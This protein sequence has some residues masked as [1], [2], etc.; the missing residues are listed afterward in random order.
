MINLIRQK[1]EH[2]ATSVRTPLKKIKD[3]GAKNTPARVKT[4]RLME[5]IK[6]LFLAS[7]LSLSIISAGDILAQRVGT[8]WTIPSQAQAQVKE[9]EDQ[10]TLIISIAGIGSY[11]KG[12]SGDQLFNQVQNM[13]GTKG[14]QYD[15]STVNRY[16]I[17]R[18]GGPDM[19]PEA[20]KAEA[21]QFAKDATQSRHRIIKFQT[22]IPGIDDL[23]K[24][25]VK[26]VSLSNINSLA[27]H[28]T[29]TVLNNPDNSFKTRWEAETR[30]GAVSVEA[31][32]RKFKEENPNARVILVGHSAGTDLIDLIPTVDN[33]TGKRL[34]DLRVMSSPRMKTLKYN[35]E[36]D[37]ARTLFITHKSDFP[38]SP[39]GKLNVPTAGGNLESQGL[40]IEM[41][42]G[43]KNNYN[44]YE[45]HH[46]TF[47]Y[48]KD[49]K[50]LIK[51]PGGHVNFDGKPEDIIRKV[52]DINS[53]P[54]IDGISAPDQLKKTLDIE[55]SRASRVGGVTFD[56]PAEVPLDPSD[57]KE[58]I[59]EYPFDAILPEAAG[60]R[61]Y[62]FSFLMKSGEK[63]SLPSINP[64][65]AAE[66]FLCIN[67]GFVPEIGLTTVRDTENKL[68]KQ[69]DY[70]NCKEYLPF[71][72]LGDILFE[73]DNL[74]GEIAFEKTDAVKSPMFIKNFHNYNLLSYDNKLNDGKQ[75]S[76]IWLNPSS[77]RTELFVD[78][79]KCTTTRMQYHFTSYDINR[80]SEFY[81]K[82]YDGYSDPAGEFLSDQLTNNFEDLLFPE[83]AIVPETACFTGA[84]LW[85]YNNHIPVSQSTLD[86]SLRILNIDRTR[87]ING[88]KHALRAVQDD[89]TDNVIFL[90]NKPVA[91]S[92]NP[93][94]NDISRPA[95]IFDQWGLSRLL[96]EDGTQSVVEHNDNMKGR[97][98][99]LI[100]RQNDKDGK[101]DI[102]TI[103]YDSD[104]RLIAMV[105]SKYNGIAI[106]WTKGMPIL[107]RHVSVDL[108]EGNV[109]F[110][111]YTQYEMVDDVSNVFDN[112]LATW[113]EKQ[114]K[115]EP[116]DGWLTL[117][118]WYDN[119]P[120][121]ELLIIIVLIVL[122][123]QLW[124][125]WPT[126][127]D[128]GGRIVQLL[129]HLKTGGHQADAGGK[130]TPP[131]PDHV[132]RLLMKD[133]KTPSARE[134]LAKIGD[135]AVGQLV[136][137]V[138]SRA[139]NLRNVDHAFDILEKIASP[140]SVE[141][142]VEMLTKT[143]YKYRQQDILRILAAV[144]SPAAERLTAL[145]HA[146]SGKYVSPKIESLKV[147]I[148]DVLKKI[149][150]PH[151]VQAL[152]SLLKKEN[153]VDKVLETIGMLED[154][155]LAFLR[156]NVEALLSLGWRPKDVDEE[157]VGYIVNPKA[158]QKVSNEAVGSLIN[159]LKSQKYAVQVGAAMVLERLAEPKAAESLIAVMDNGRLGETARRALIRIGLD[160]VIPLTKALSSSKPEIKAQVL[161][162]LKSIDRNSVSDLNK[163]L[164]NSDIIDLTSAIKSKNAS[165]RLAAVK[166][167]SQK[168]KNAQVIEFL[169]ECMKDLEYEVKK[170]VLEILE[171]IDTDGVSGLARALED[172]DLKVCWKAIEVLG[173]KEKNNQVIVLLE[174]ALK[175]PDIYLRLEAVRILV[176]HKEI[177]EQV[178]TVLKETLRN[179]PM[180]EKLAAANVILQSQ[181]SGLTASMA[182]SVIA[183]M[184]DIV[185][186]GS[187]GYRSE[188]LEVIRQIK[189]FQGN[190]LLAKLTECVKEDGGEADIEKLLNNSIYEDKIRIL[191]ILENIEK[192]GVKGLRVSIKDT[193]QRVRL[194]VVELLGLKK[195]NDQ[196]I[197]LLEEALLDTDFSV[198]MESARALIS[199][200]EKN[201][202]LIAFL[203]IAIKAPEYKLRAQAM[204]E[205]I[206]IGPVASGI[207]NF[208]ADIKDGG[209]DAHLA[210]PEADKTE[211][212]AVRTLFEK[213][214]DTNAIGSD[215]AVEEL[216][217][218][219]DPLL[220]KTVTASMRGES[221]AVREA[222]LNK[223]IKYRKYFSK[224]ELN[225]IS[226]HDFNILAESRHARRY[227]LMTAVLAVDDSR[228]TE[229]LIK[230]L[231]NV[232]SNEA[233]I[234]ALCSSNNPQ[235]IE[236]LLSTVK[237][238]AVEQDIR[239]QIQG[240][241]IRF[242]NPRVFMTLKDL[243]Y[244]RNEFT[245]VRCAA[246]EELRKFEDP[247][248][249]VILKNLFEDKNE[250]PEVHSAVEKALG[251]IGDQ[252]GAKLLKRAR[253]G[254][255]L[256]ESLARAGTGLA[257]GLGTLLLGGVGLV[258]GLVWLAVIIGV[259][260]LVLWLF[261]Y[262]FF[263]GLP[264][265]IVYIVLL[266][267]IGVFNNST[268]ND[269]HDQKAG[270]L[271]LPK[272]LSLV[273]LWKLESV[274]DE[275]IALNIAELELVDSLRPADYVK[276]FNEH[277]RFYS[278]GNLSRLFGAAAMWVS[279]SFVYLCGRLHGLSAGLAMETARK[280]QVS[281]HAKW[282]MDEIGR[283]VS[284][285]QLSK[286][287]G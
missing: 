107:C 167:L 261:S 37:N 211:S 22:E 34:V 210:A 43:L 102:T 178:E 42:G 276:F 77:I 93:D 2:A 58:L 86:S 99:K 208:K 170:Q 142:L 231:K 21:K 199:H 228:S 212:Q 54:I 246:I 157:I 221:A 80:R 140:G 190:V 230:A 156:L 79:L 260:I 150:G 158:I 104:G 5:K 61:N 152:E 235:S 32:I 182:E 286:V 141:P 130:E 20:Q 24:A 83:L 106:I 3:K 112:L 144:G 46:K 247:G 245:K 249:F 220:E 18:R 271:I 262:S 177:N 10:P 97:I 183:G 136:K 94:L 179:P 119:L 172:S 88:N 201:D 232:D 239:C 257:K 159:E 266:S 87:I 207:A 28:L 284:G 138:Q 252:R 122:G 81:A 213:V 117:A 52:Q 116:T 173:R 197:A 133:I 202:S 277:F 103:L 279:T 274:P 161:E 269:H 89:N 148:I 268:Y 222:V 108:Q 78:R 64:A 85:A 223:F 165:M 186:H 258:I 75:S 196:V 17:T 154:N 71:T 74:S 96:W 168:N 125:F 4:S 275:T 188:G 155:N 48:D 114:T 236:L 44:P 13:F 164:K 1:T 121:K 181:D 134:A 225:N 111:R 200:G 180:N 124:I 109:Y 256:R 240:A 127:G 285:E 41:H 191:E 273:S 163:D 70:K 282:D 76:I 265:A 259:G 55:K 255:S 100:G 62:G 7:L 23:V 176:R 6:M 278:G 226:A 36:G 30:R 189:E 132:I 203:K 281:F 101:K 251:K 174:E 47:E 69:A 229:L 59:F 195:K 73:A 16:D 113:F 263:L 25:N 115:N 242:K 120:I 56:K 19:T 237:D 162:I 139:F 40:V 185:E 129:K 49:V 153:P 149:G 98:E 35:S 241:L 128:G 84:L 9:S 72:T 193:N 14:K 11:E 244:D 146:N 15:V 12:R 184:K 151:T 192:D 82:R 194:K 254:A 90:T 215:Q 216:F 8:S 287:I 66:A 131:E 233:A 91:E 160:A 39:F 145:L 27:R 187:S 234:E 137:A 53:R 95:P 243:S 26:D 29:D 38:A 267:K 143:A 238:K 205:A 65:T 272:N 209:A 280:V 57:I 105:D 224:H 227:L 45:A 171:K 50:M 264:A 63:I 219:W 270:H 175:N 51:T 147:Q 214:K 206:G 250:D 135:P 253:M 110:H 217:K 92:H 169:E 218:I 126:G 118:H 60:N 31:A 166:V 198:G 67:K 68:W 204:L 123:L 283:I 33:T 248:V